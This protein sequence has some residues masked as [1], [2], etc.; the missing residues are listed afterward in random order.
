VAAPVITGFVVD[1]NSQFFWAFAVAAA[2]VLAGAS[3]YVFALGPVEP[4]KWSRRSA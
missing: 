3:I 1:K 2:V 4:V